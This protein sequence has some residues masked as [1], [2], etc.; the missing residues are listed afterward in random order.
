MVRIADMPIGGSANFDELVPAFADAERWK[1]ASERQSLPQPAPGSPLAGDVL[2]LEI[3]PGTHLFRAGLSGAIDHLDA[4]RLLI[5]EVE[6]LHLMAPVTLLRAVLED[7]SLALW[8]TSPGQQSERLLRAL[9]AHYTDMKG[10]AGYE[11]IQ[12]PRP[13]LKGKSAVQ[14][15][16]DIRELAVK[17]GLDGKDVSQHLSTTRVITEACSVLGGAG[18]DGPRLWSLSSGLAHGRHWTVI[19]GYKLHGATDVGGGFAELQ[20]TSNEDEVKSMALLG[21]ALIQ[22]ALARYEVLSH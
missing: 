7:A 18:S 3:Y 6:A 4:F 13:G 12:P 14:R 10:R 19:H 5:V 15:C 2:Q 21:H 1:N 16:A 20:V 17:L 8:L 22:A 9:K 11:K